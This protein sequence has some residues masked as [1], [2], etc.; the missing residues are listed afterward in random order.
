MLAGDIAQDRFVRFMQS[1][2]VFFFAQNLCVFRKSFARYL[3]YILQDQPKLL[4]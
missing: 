1:A 4:F 3:F 2:Y